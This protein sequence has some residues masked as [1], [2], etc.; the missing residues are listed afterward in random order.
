MSFSTIGLACDQKAAESESIS[1]E[2][3]GV[4]VVDIVVGEWLWR[5]R[6]IGVVVV[7]LSQYDR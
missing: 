3:L 6:R 5:N 4:R 2:V 1:L 7:V